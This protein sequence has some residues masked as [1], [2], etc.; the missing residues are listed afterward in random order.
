M[1][2]PT[3]GRRP[4][5][6]IATLMILSLVVGLAAACASGAAAPQ[7]PGGVA[8]GAGAPQAAPTF[9]PGDNGAGGGSTGNG[10]N[11]GKGAG[12]PSGGGDAVGLLDQSKIVRTGSLQL[13]VADVPRALLGARDAIRS[14]GGYIGASQQ[15]RS[16]DDVLASVTYRIPVARWEEAL[17]AIRSLGTEIG[18]QTN[19][20]EV[21][22]QLVDLA[23]RIRN[24]KA[25]ETALV[26]YAANAPK[27][28]DLLEIESRLTETRSEI[29]RLTA[30]QTQLQ[31]QAALA[32]LTVT[33]GVEAV[34]VLR[35]AERWDP[36]AEVDRATATLIAMGQAVVSFAIVFGIVWVPLL[37]T[38]SI[39]GLIALAA[40]RRLGVRRPDRF[41]PLAPP[42]SSAEV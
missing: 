14:V 34:E 11:A 1:R 8:S 23:A 42:P 9:A 39:I 36:A 33:F 35:T 32:T 25:S 17:D 28:T 6:S 29:E 26:G 19:A 41:P 4:G 20:V 10:N 16:G 7:A 40:A 2:S 30:Q 31:D 27:V 5:R 22:G 18:E 3:L 37:L 15:E 21:T 13:T 24:L 38:F 12:S